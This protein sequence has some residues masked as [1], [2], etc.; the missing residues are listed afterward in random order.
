MKKHNSISKLVSNNPLQYAGY[1]AVAKTRAKVLKAFAYVVP[2]RRPM[3]FVGESSCDELCDM[4]INEGSS[5][6]FIVTD[7]VL[8]KLGIP[9]KIT[10]YLDKKNISYTVYDGITPDPTFQVVEEGLRKSV[11]A[12][13][14]SIIAIG[15][16]SVI[17]A[18]KM[19]AMSQGNNC[20]P[21]QLMGILKARKPSVPLYC[22]PTTAGTGSEA[23]LGAVVSDDKTH[24]K[25]LSIDPK[26]VPLAAAIDPVIM[27]GMPAHITADTGIDVL[28]HALEAWM[29][30]N[31]SVET[32]YY[33]ASAA[34]S[35]MQNLPLVYKDGGN[36]KA[37][38]E[39]GIA[40]HYGGIAFNKAGLGYVHAIAH[41]L[42]A[43]Y[44]IPHGRANAI[45]L[46]YVL[47]VNRKATK[48]RLAELARKTGMVQ[49]G[50]ASSSDSDITDHL[51]AQVRD[52]IASL[53]IDPMV[54]GMQSSDFDNIAKAAAK[55]VSDTYAVPTYLSASEI[56]GIL[57]KIKQASD[58]Y[59][60]SESKSDKVA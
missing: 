6:V 18:A 53:N 57:T 38:E 55:E 40:A 34:K 11:E 7:A 23:T 35:V 30:A 20:K 4:A 19:I 22:V 8:N 47:D 60:G 42:G 45:V 29:S 26:M 50:Q 51:I 58:E 48:K 46:P 39:M 5:N 9:A 12:K 2:I 3:L 56:K 59:A 28:T 41:Q 24:Q 49:V 37:R 21:K 31:A 32:D 14:D 15:G 33:A 17:D 1:L 52:L 10:D 27:K 13:C 54:K 43:Y 44:H 36:L 25:S 16:G